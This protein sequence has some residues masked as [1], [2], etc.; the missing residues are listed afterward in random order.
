[1][2]VET[3][4]K[5]EGLL[6]VF[7]GA[8]MVVDERGQYRE[9]LPVGGDEDL[10]VADPDDL[11]GQRFEDL[12]DEAR[13]ERFLA[14]VRRAIET[15]SPQRIEYEMDVRT[16]RRWFE[17]A[18]VPVET[19]PDAPAAVIWAAQDV[20]D[21][22]RF[23]E[24][25]ASLHEAGT[26]I[27]S[28]GTAEE[29]CEE[30]VHAAEHILDLDQS[31]IALEAGGV[32]EVTA[33]SEQLS[34]DEV[35]TMSVEEG[36]AGQTYRTGE[37]VLVEDVS[38]VEAAI[39][40]TPYRSAISVPIGD[41]GNF[42]AVAEAPGA[43]DETDL[44]LAE[45][46]V[47]QVDAALTRLGHERQLRE[48]N[49]RLDEF[50]RIVSHDLRNPMNV[51][52]GRLEL[53]QDDCDSEHLS[54]AIDALERME[55]L[56]DNLLELARTGETE[57]EHERVDLPAVLRSCWEVVATEEATLKIDVDRSVRANPSELRQCFE[58]LFGN[59][60]EH[61]GPAVTVTVGELEDG[62]YVEDDGYGLPD[63][64]PDRLFESGVSTT[65]GGTGFGLH[66][67]ATIAERHGWEVT[68]CEGTDGGARFEIREIEPA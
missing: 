46:L 52:A 63:V 67:V 25:L 31:A 64:D 33:T 54:R 17:A 28:R 66:I 32:L 55:S 22:K 34:T 60:I 14:T 11:V 49:E 51:A 68:A 18:V 62:V 48:Q 27:T 53:A 5:F 45:I 9:A 56:V 58:N 30:A 44:E 24:S 47:S 4:S 38:D 37:S 3:R 26:A 36:L 43:F 12:F 42:Q 19:K 57:R 39:K 1:M 20:T 15:D 41:Q 61:G 40:S 6:D 50:A 59:A 7:S 21:R 10:L 35:T 2:W 65:N 16:G 23:E 8:V 29:V 13:A